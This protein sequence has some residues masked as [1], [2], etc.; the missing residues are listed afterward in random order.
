[1]LTTYPHRSIATL[2]H[3][4]HNNLPENIRFT[5]AVS[6]PTS[7]WHDLHKVQE[8]FEAEDQRGSPCEKPPR[9]LHPLANEYHLRHIHHHAWIPWS[10]LM[11]SQIN[12]QCAS[13]TVFATSHRYRYTME[14]ASWLRKITIRRLGWQTATVAMFHNTTFLQLSNGNLVNTYPV[15]CLDKNDHRQTVYPFVPAYGKVQG[16]M[17]KSAIIWFDVPTVPAGSTYVALSRV[18]RLRGVFFMTAMQ[19]IHFTAVQ[20]EA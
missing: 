4:R 15:N 17:L 11:A 1:M 9:H 8:W 16:Q 7:I 14:C 3:P 5:A 19:L 6:Q 13:Y 10:S 2:L 20:M 12:N 18:K